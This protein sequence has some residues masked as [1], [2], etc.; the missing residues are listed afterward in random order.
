MLPAALSALMA[1]LSCCEVGQTKS[2][3]MYEWLVEHYRL[4]LRV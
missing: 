4:T 2:G 3:E 1:E